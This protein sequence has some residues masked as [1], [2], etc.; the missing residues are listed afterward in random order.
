M[1][2]TTR[3]LADISSMQTGKLNS[4]A[5]VP[6]GIF[7]F[8][9]CAQETYS[10]NKAA[11]NT[12]AVLL[13]G[14]NA[15]GVFPLKYYNGEFNAYQRTYIIETLDRN[16]LDTRYLFYAL[17]PAL[18][19]FQAASIGAA[20]QY[21]TKSILDNFKIGV[22]DLDVQKRI[23][24]LL[25]AYDDLIENNRCRIASLEDAARLL[26]REWFVHF[27]FPGHEHVK[28]VEGIP[29]GWKPRTLVELAEVVMGQSPKSQF[30]NEAGEGLPF[31][32]GVTDYGFRFVSHRIHSSAV[33]K[34]A[35]AGDILVSVRAPVGRINITQ[36]RIVLGRGLAAIRSRT[37]QQSFLLY[38]LKNHFYAEDIIGTGAIY[39]ATNKKELE[40][41]IF[42]EPSASLLREFEDQANTIDLQIAC[43]T[44]Q[45][46]NLVRAR[47][48]LLPRLMSGEIAV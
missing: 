20:T 15:N 3:K 48:L 33:T 25:S 10:I 9:T 16:V 8:F 45:S 4:N 39:A 41:Q 43:L 19:K 44:N 32:Q 27:R 47:D 5:A 37:E 14:N 29:A 30:Y 24:N 11:F 21:L 13:G 1:S 38:A 7:P 23:V 34:I 36:D 31:H 28:I 35:E 6:N 42:L 46:H 18:S 17:Q 12:E 22:P 26:Y 2:I 40:G